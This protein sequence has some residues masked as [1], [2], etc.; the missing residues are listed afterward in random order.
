MITSTGIETPLG[1]MLASAEEGALTGLWFIGQQ[2]F[3][4]GAK[5][6]PEDGAAA[7]FETLRAQLAEYFGGRR[8]QFDLPMNPGGSRATA[9]QRAV[10]QA[11][12]EVKFGET[13]TYSALAARC[14]NPSAAR[15]AGAATG[16]NPISLLIP[17]HRIVGSS[18]ALTGYAGGLERKRSLLA[19]E[20]G[21]DFASDPA[22]VAEWVEQSDIRRILDVTIA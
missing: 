13:T 4:E 1:P 20:R 6:W 17:C 18:G 22:E 2:H 7:V 9:F 8:R 21:G 14:G 12:A 16:R 3:P 10:W 5:G 19:L 15:A 11:I